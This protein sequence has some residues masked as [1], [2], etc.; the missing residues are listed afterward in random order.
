MRFYWME[1]AFDPDSLHVDSAEPLQDAV[2]LGRGD[3]RPAKPLSFHRCEGYHATDLIGTTHG[4]FLISDR[5][6]DALQ[7]G[8]FTGWTTYAVEVRGPG[9][10]HIRG[11]HGLAVT[12]RCGPLDES[13]SEKAI[14]R[15]PPGG[16]AMP[17]LRG[18]Y[19]DL[20]TWDGSDIFAPEGTTA[21]F[22]VERVKTAL[23][24]IK[25][26]NMKFDDLTKVEQLM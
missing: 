18:V 5:V 13:R 15:P 19:F 1:N 25:V 3:V 17:G 24:A 21:T 11:Y 26:T 12:G 23:Q 2:G 14:L 10:R 6:V 16:Q 4:L 7:R 20:G 8:A 22:V 9:G